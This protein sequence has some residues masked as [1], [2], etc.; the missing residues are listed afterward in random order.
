MQKWQFE[1]TICFR[2]KSITIVVEK[3][4]HGETTGLKSKPV[5]LSVLDSLFIL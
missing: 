4:F 5:V 1:K 2:K 3:W